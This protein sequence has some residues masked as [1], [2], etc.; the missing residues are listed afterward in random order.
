MAVF[1]NIVQTLLSNSKDTERYARVDLVRYLPELKVSFNGVLTRKVLA[2]TAQS[3]RYAQDRQVW[4]S[5]AGERLLAQQT[6]KLGVTLPIAQGTYDVIGTTIYKQQVELAGNLAV[7]AG[8]ITRLDTLGQVAAIVVHALNVK[9]LDMKGVYALKTG[10]NQIAAKVEARDVPML[11]PGG[12]SY[13]IALEQSVGL[14][15]IRSGLT[16]SPASW[17]TYVRFL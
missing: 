5:E 10:T 1:Q 2:K 13:D 7:I 3:G 17:W 12:A 6:D 8:Q 9:G 14:T 15:R 11:V 16:P 4:R